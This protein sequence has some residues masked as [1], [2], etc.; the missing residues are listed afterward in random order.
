MQVCPVTGQLSIQVGDTVQ[1]QR[2]ALEGTVIDI[3]ESGA[4]WGW[5]VEV[6]LGEG[7]SRTF[8][9]AELTVTQMFG[10][11]LHG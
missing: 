1:T 3:R 10:W 6:E 4:R 9:S 11:G 2:G 8:D 5:E 7:S